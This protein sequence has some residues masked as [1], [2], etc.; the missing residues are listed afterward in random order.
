MTQT[1]QR[2]RASSNGDA[3]AVKGPVALPVDCLRDA[4]LELRRP[5]AANAVKFKVQATWPKGNPTS[6]LIVPYVDSRLVVE[7]WP[8][9]RVQTFSGLGET[10]APRRSLHE[11][12]SEPLLESS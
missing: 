6:A 11:R 4:A 1:V 5:F 2:P 7:R 3:P 8:R 12:D 10:D 9:C